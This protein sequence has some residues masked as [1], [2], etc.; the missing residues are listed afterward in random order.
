M[1]N[2]KPLASPHALNFSFKHRYFDPSKAIKELGWKPKQ[3]F[4]TAIKKAIEFY[5]EQGLM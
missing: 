2:K 4:E 1:F 5:E 3:N